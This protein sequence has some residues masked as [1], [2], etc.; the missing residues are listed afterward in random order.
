MAI[1]S[2]GPTEMAPRQVSASAR[3]AQD[4]RTYS[5]NSGGDNSLRTANCI[6]GDGDVLYDP[7]ETA[8]MHAAA[9]GDTDLVEELLAAG[10]DV[11]A[12]DQRGQTAL[13]HA[14]LHG[15]SS[16]ELTRALLKSG[17]DVNAADR[18]GRTPLLFAVQTERSIPGM[19]LHN[20]AAVVRELL[21]AH[22]NVNV[23]DENGLTPLM[24]A[25]R[26]A[27]AQTVKE[28]LRAGADVNARDNEG[29]TALSVAETKG[30]TEIVQPLK[31]WGAN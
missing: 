26:D 8:L 4:Q 16:P 9:K 10:A 6:G 30:R 3:L 17:A 7:D 11:N 21:A 31:Q 19:S 13:I 29:H 25:A 14:C 23:K 20:G 24:M 12:R 2:C 22:A 5:R 15:N 18:P 27:D 28:L 1:P